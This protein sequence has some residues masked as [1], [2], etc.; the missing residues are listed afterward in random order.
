MSYRRRSPRV[1]LPGGPALAPSDEAVF[2]RNVQGSKAGQR[3]KKLLR[4]V[5]VYTLITA[6]AAVVGWHFRETEQDDALVW[7]MVGFGCVCLFALIH[8]PL[9][10]IMWLIAWARS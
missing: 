2:Q 1:A 5:F 4:A 8:V 7:S 9:L 3:F 6:A 10:A